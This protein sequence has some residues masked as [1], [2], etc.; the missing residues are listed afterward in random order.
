MIRK[1]AAMFDTVVHSPDIIHSFRESTTVNFDYHG[2]PMDISCRLLEYGL[3]DRRKRMFFDHPSPPFSRIFIFESGGTEIAT[4]NG[5]FRLKKGKIYL[6]PSGQRFQ[7]SYYISK[8]LFFH[9]HICDASERSLFDGTEG[10]PCIDDPTLYER[11]IGAFR[12]DDMFGML[13]CLTE[14]LHKLLLPRLDEIAGR[15]ARLRNFSQLFEAM[16]RTKPASVN[17]KTLSELYFISQN[18][19]SKRFRREMGFP[20]KKYLTDHLILQ[21]QKLLLHSNYSNIEIAEM[22]GFN[23]PQYFHR[24]F[25]KNCKLTPGEY[26]NRN[27]FR[28]S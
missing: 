18:S 12:A 27:R 15:A 20:L 8:L 28:N 17:V 24:F 9:L 11:F 2:I 4:G 19:L 10:I 5:K 13:C 14:T 25:R 7:S 26:R 23:T 16:R 3:T 21:A 6:L 1:D 22:L